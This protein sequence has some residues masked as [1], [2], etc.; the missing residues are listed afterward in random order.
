MMPENV[1]MLNTKFKRNFLNHQKMKLFE[2]EGW[3]KSN[4]NIK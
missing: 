1:F 4:Q 2:I 3:F